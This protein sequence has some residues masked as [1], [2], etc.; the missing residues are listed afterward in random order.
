MNYLVEHLQLAQIHIFNEPA[1]ICFIFLV[2][3]RLY[4]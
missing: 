1:E 2:I 3:H 4:Q